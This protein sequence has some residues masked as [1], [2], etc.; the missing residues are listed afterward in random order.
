[1]LPIILKKYD[2]S[3]IKKPFT[4]T[5]VGIP[6]VGKSTF[7]NSLYGAEYEIIS[8]DGIMMELHGNDNYREAFDAIPQEVLDGE[9][10]KR[11][12]GL[13][14]QEK[15]VVFDITNTVRKRRQRNLGQYSRKK[16][17][18]IAVIF[19]TPSDS[20]LKERNLERMKTQ[21]KLIPDNVLLGFAINYQAVTADEGFDII[22]NL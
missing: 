22:I 4:I 10:S 6:L 18:H 19:T 3:T 14:K 1:M 13:A 2:L 17:T 7:I 9:I 15:N 11:I 16:Y 21:N 5:L 20:V 12:I 8:S